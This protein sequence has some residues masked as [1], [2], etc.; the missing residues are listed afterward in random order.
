MPAMQ[1][2]VGLA[3]GVVLITL[4]VFANAPIW[5]VVL[6]TATYGVLATRCARPPLG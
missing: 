2:A 6:A 5:L 3:I 4:L 1:Y